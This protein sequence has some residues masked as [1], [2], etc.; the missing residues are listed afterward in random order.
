MKSKHVPHASAPLDRIRAL[1]AEGLSLRQIAEQLQQDGVPP[2][3]AD[4]RWHHNTVD[5]PPGPRGGAARGGPHPAPGL[6]LCPNS[7]GLS[8]C[9]PARKN[10]GAVEGGGYQP[11]GVSAA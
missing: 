1:K 3:G 7:S 8:P 5:P 4:S 9:P 2:P 10:S 11:L 6:S